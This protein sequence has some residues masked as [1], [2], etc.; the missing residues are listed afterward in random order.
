MKSSLA[1]S[2][3]F[4]SLRQS[5]QRAVQRSGT[6]VAE[7]PD[8]QLA[9]NSPILSALPLYIAMRFCM[10]ALRA[11][12]AFSPATQIIIAAMVAPIKRLDKLR[13]WRVKYRREIFST[14]RAKKAAKL[15]D[16]AQ[17]RHWQS[18]AGASGGWTR[19][20]VDAISGAAGQD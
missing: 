15:P 14:R 13:C 2:P 18:A 8:E 11:S 17:R 5:G 1:S 16:R 4:A 10:D 3:S 20:R 6:L 9:P 19:C 12:T 7:R